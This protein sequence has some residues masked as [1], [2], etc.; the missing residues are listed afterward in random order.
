MLNLD[1]RREICYLNFNINI[2]FFCFLNLKFIKYILFIIV[3][4]FIFLECFQRKLKIVNVLVEEKRVY[5]VQGLYFG[6]SILEFIQVWLEIYLF[7]YV[8]VYL[9][10]QVEKLIR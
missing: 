1:K 10:F 7:Y 4:L 3:N 2:F 6:E 8:F 5:Y 9:E